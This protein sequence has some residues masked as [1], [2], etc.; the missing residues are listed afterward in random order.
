MCMGRDGNPQVSHS[1]QKSG[2]D[3]TD[4]LGEGS[5]SAL[6]QKNLQE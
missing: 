2:S 4:G 5:V 6:V 1:S 3:S